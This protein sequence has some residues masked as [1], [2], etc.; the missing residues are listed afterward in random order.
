MTEDNSAYSLHFSK[1]EDERVNTM[2]SGRTRAETQVQTRRLGQVRDCS[3]S[4]EVGS[5]AYCRSK[6]GYTLGKGGKTGI[7]EKNEAVGMTHPSPVGV[8]SQ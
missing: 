8:K 2:A 5:P 1:R 4:P 3:C 6:Q 7:T